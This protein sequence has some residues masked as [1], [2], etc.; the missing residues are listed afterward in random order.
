[1]RFGV[2]LNGQDAFE[3]PQLS[4]SLNVTVMGAPSPLTGNFMFF[5]V[6]VASSK[7]HVSWLRVSD[8]VGIE[9]VEAEI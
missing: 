7:D 1:V 8:V 3:L 5:S 2:N 6:L 4:Y 9:V